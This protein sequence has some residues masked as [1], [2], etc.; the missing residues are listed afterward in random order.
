MCLY[1]HKVHPKPRN[2][3]TC[4]KIYSVEVNLKSGKI[5]LVPPYWGMKAVNIKKPIVPTRASKREALIIHPVVGSKIDGGFIHVYKTQKEALKW[6]GYDGEVV[7]LKCEAFGVVAEGNSSHVS[8]ETTQ[9]ICEK[10]I[11]VDKDVKK[12]IAA[13]VTKIKKM[14]DN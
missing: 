5:K 3:V 2:K 7:V 6:A 8:L 12:K 10:L 4:Y 1:V 13:V 14:Y 11:V 9:L